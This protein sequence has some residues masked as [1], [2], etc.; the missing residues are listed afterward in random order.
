[1][2]TYLA[3]MT[4][5]GYNAAVCLGV[6]AMATGCQRCARIAWDVP[7]TKKTDNHL[8]LAVG[9]LAKLSRTGGMGNS[10]PT[11]D[12]IG[13]HTFTVFALPVGN[14]KADE[15][16]PVKESFERTSFVAMVHGCTETSIGHRFSGFL[17]GC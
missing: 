13:N 15:S 8:T 17:T 16:T 12:I 1:M 9:D 4:K 11:E 2:A 3:L 7:A 10:E 14:I 5:H 6:V